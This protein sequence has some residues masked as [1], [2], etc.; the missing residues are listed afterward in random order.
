MKSFAL[1]HSKAVR[2]SVA[3]II[4]VS[5]VVVSLI[6]SG[7]S[8]G[9]KLSHDGNETGIIK[10]AKVFDSAKKMAVSSVDGAAEC[11]FCF[12][13]Y[14]LQ[15]VL[16]LESRMSTIGEIADEMINSNNE[17]VYGTEIIVDGKRKLCVKN[18]DVE[19]Y[20][21]SRLAAFDIKGAK[22]KHE[23]MSD[24]EIKSAYLLASDLA[25]ISEITKFLDSLDVKTTSV[26]ETK[27][28]IPYKTVTE[29]TSMQYVGYSSVI[30]SGVKGVLAKRQSVVYVNGVEVSSKELAS[31]VVSEPV[32]EVVLIGTKQVSSSTVKK[33]G[34]IFP[35]PKGTYVQ[36]SYYGDGRGHKG[37]DYGA[38][39]GTSIFSVKSGT[40]TFSGS[41]GNYG[42]CVIVDHGNGLKTLYAHCDKLLVG[43]GEKVSAGQV[44]GTVGNTGRSTG[45]HLHFELIV[46]GSNVNPAP[47]LGAK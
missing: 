17:V 38:D 35:L 37:L 3:G 39:R 41:N 25:E 7:V 8:I 26:V 20:L 21:E 22:N 24:I 30:S 10:T 28:S 14:K 6:C 42:L 40:V 31:Q 4:F 46:N 1:Q 12:E 33:L 32:D 34:F 47:Y 36:T 9:F 16:T 18:F 43:K 13:N 45:N 15:K 23:F 29:K 2:F 44:I 5:A 27:E 11:D 19:D